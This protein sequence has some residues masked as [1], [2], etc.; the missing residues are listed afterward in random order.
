VNGKKVF[1]FETPF[2]L[3]FGQDKMIYLVA[4]SIY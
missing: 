4:Q 3:N 2:L 1:Q